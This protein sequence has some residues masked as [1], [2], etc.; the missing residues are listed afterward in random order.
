MKLA[1]LT[2]VKNGCPWI[3]THLEVF[4]ATGLDWIWSIAEGQAANVNCSKWCRPMPTGFS[5]DGT[6][7]YLLSLAHNPRV[8]IH[9]KKFWPGG[10]VE[11]VNDALTQ[12]KEPCILMQV[13]ADEKWR[14]EQLRRI[15][16]L[17]DSGDSR[18]G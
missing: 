14:A 9:C 13:D 3:K 6:H 7:E 10:K 1:I 2:I 18:P 17:F 4:E 16:E 15:V 8:K 12:I 11:M 5:T